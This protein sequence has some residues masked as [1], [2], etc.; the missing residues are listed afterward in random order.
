MCV[1]YVSSSRSNH[2]EGVCAVVGIDI[3]AGEEHFACCAP[4]PRPHRA[5]PFGGGADGG[6]G[7]EGEAVGR[8]AQ[9]E[10]L[11][12]A[13]SGGGGGG[14]N[15]P[16]HAAALRRAA[17]AGLGVTVHAGESAGGANVLLL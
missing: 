3:A 1:S 9:M 7:Y 16:V 13:S 4:R 12:R 14:G 2:H 10:L 15:G 11:R 6:G 17:A 8:A 5:R